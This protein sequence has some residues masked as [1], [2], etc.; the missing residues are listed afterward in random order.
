METVVVSE[1]EMEIIIS[2]IKAYR[3]ALAAS[4][5]LALALFA[6]GT[7]EECAEYLPRVYGRIRV[8]EARLAALYNMDADAR[9]YLAWVARKYARTN[10]SI[11][12][13]R[14]AYA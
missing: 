7:E 14:L 2:L 13:G 10:A 8:Y 3:R 1:S 11:E 5:E 4:I 9:E 12:R 6:Q